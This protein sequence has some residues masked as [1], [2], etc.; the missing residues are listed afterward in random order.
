MSATTKTPPPAQF[1]PL[2]QS[3]G[4]G[5]RPQRGLA[6]GLVAL[7]LLGWA[8]RLPLLARFPLRED[9]AIYA[10]WA[11]H[12][13]HEDPLFLTV[14]PD[15][16]PLFLWTLAAFL[17]VARPED[18]LQAE[19]LARWVNV[20]ASVLTIPLI[21][22]IARRWWG[23]PAGWV[24]AAGMAF[25]PYAIAFAPTVYTDTLLV[26]GGVAALACAVCRRWFWA[27]VWLGAAIMTKQ[28]GLAYV[29]LLLG[30]WW[31]LG[32][33]PT[34]E[35]RPA[36]LA[37]LVGGAL[38]LVLPIIYWDSLRWAVAPSPWDLAQRNYGPLQ[39]VALI[40]W[41]ARLAAWGE[42][43]WYLAGAW[44]VWGVWSVGLVL[45][46]A[47]RAPR[48]SASRWSVVWLALWSLGFLALHVGTTVQI[49]DRYLL[50]LAPL[51][52]LSLGWM[53][54]RVGAQ[55]QYWRWVGSQRRSIWVVGL[56]LVGLLAQPAWQAGQGRY[57]LG[58]DHGDYAGLH[59]ALGWL[60]ANGGPRFVLYHRALGWHYPFYLFD[61]L[62][63]GRVE[64]RW[65]PNPPGLADNAAKT[66]YPP[67]YLIVPA[68][69]AQPQLGLH[70]QTRGQ[71]LQTR[72]V[73]GNFRVLEIVHAPQPLCRWCASR[74]PAVPWRLA[75]PVEPGMMS[76]P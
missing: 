54:G 25:N 61:D 20:A 1:P 75:Q 64:L 55:A 45:G 43:I 32:R 68:W 17:G 4:S 14:W 15:K 30:I 34:T 58:G 35:A 13:L 70:L 38:L 57:P 63:A 28:Q 51:F 41:P 76:Q 65:F 49:W 37:R 56:A 42:W 29:P 21:G 44:W 67:K 39:A 50:P 24:A 46:L 10:Y 53:W 71:T 2:E 26:L 47:L 72:L 73:A 3:N 27:G 60:D 48:S 40:E 31:T 12:F 11:L 36:A 69:A 66:A 18:A 22:A 52:A 5:T 19:A 9:E 7:C 62:R 8:V 59:Q 33:D 16:P 74:L 6:W 23:A